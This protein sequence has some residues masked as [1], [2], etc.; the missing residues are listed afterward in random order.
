MKKKLQVMVDD[1]QMRFVKRVA[2]RKDCTIS[3]TIMIMIQEAM[4]REQ[5]NERAMPMAL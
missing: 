2:K 1:E 5:I 4:E 3:H